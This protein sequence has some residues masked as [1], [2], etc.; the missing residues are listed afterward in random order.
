MNE[1]STNV[2]AR[3]CARNR[4]PARLSSNWIHTDYAIMISC[5]VVFY[6]CKG[7]CQKCNQRT[8]TSPHTVCKM[9]RP[10]THTHTKS[11]HTARVE[12]KK[13]KKGKS[14]DLQSQ[15]CIACASSAVL[16]IHK[17]IC[18]YCTLGT[19]KKEKVFFPFPFV[20]CIWLLCFCYDDKNE[21]TGLQTYALISQIITVIVVSLL[22][23]PSNFTQHMFLQSVLFN[24]FCCCCFF[25]VH[26]QRTVSV[27]SSLWFPPL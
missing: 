3:S 25:R 26:M 27:C 18:M 1:E 4:L 22:I 12:E 24:N 10:T 16:T 9:Q 23:F 2:C 13:K 11:S 19:Y 21:W 7:N 14:N 17:C 20:C 6:D 15:Q 8:N 5:V